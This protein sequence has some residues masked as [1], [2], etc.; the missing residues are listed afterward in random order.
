MARGVTTVVLLHSS[1]LSSRQWAFA[2]AR[3]RA[4]GDTVIVPDLV[5][6]GE[7]EPWPEPRPFT[8]RE[9]V[10][11]LAELIS[12]QPE[13]IVLGGHSYGGF[14]AL[15]AAL[16]VPDRIAALWLYDPVAFGTLDPARDAE[17]ITE[18]AAIE[19]DWRR[20]AERWMTSF[21]DYW[22]GPGAFA[23]LR[24]PMRAE[25]LRVAWVVQEGV[26]SLTLDATPASAYRAIAAPA[27]LATGEHSPIAARRVIE[28]L[29]EV[30]HATTATIAGA[31]HMG[32][33]THA[34]QVLRHFIS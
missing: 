25:F 34:E 20:G 30:L 23:A 1:G 14:L 8:F 27:R 12:A 28:R 21:V 18:L 32:P 10:A 22:G 7:A 5:G 19:L 33:M 15:Q 26:R 11:R 4:R 16:A 29:G 24:P 2:A 31:G 13:P 17:A 9:D 3:L 6:H